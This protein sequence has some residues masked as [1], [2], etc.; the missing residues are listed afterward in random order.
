MKGITALSRELK[1]L[2][3]YTPQPDGKNTIVWTTQ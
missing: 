2:I 1:K 3:I